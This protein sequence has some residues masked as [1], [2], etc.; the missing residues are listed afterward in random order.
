MRARATVGSWVAAAGLAAVVGLTS[1]C[2]GRDRDV[3]EWRADD[4]AQPAESE[5]PPQ[6]PPVAEPPGPEERGET[7]V[8][9]DVPVPGAAPNEPAPTPPHVVAP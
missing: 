5:A 3:R 2:S 7:E 8:G 4:H 9:P 1:G 6:A